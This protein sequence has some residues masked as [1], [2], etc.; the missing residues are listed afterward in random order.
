MEAAFYVKMIF[1]EKLKL[2]KK[3]FFMHM[4]HNFFLQKSGSI[5]VLQNVF[6]V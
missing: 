4:F 1:R 2:Q 6:M 5:K 3:R